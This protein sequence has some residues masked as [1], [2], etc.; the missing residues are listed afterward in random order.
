MRPIL[1]LI[2]RSEDAES[3]SVDASLSVSEAREIV[4]PSLSHYVSS[5]FNRGILS[6]IVGLYFD[7][8]HLVSKVGNLFGSYG[9]DLGGLS[10]EVLAEWLRMLVLNFLVVDDWGFLRLV[11]SHGKQFFGFDRGLL[12]LMVVVEHGYALGRAVQSGIGQ[13]TI[14]IWLVIH[15]M[16]GQGQTNQT[17]F[18]Q[19]KFCSNEV[20]SKKGAPSWP[21][22][23]SKRWRWTQMRCTSAAGM[24]NQRSINLLPNETIVDLLKGELW[25][26]MG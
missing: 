26:P 11:G 8:V 21:A 22:L 12:G 5:A 13:W 25:C 16:V 4:E 10:V 14:R 18:I 2:H 23:A 24:N 9:G 15:A 1:T 7:A 6:S 20:T 3:N 19:T 17:R